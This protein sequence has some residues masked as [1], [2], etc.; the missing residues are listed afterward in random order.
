MS[1]H[2]TRLLLCAGV[3]LGLILVSA[4]GMAWF[5]LRIEGLKVAGMSVDGARVD[6]RSISMCENGGACVLLPFSKIDGL[7][8][9]MST[10]TFWSS[11]VLAII[12]AVQ[13]GSRILRGV[14]GEGI[15][16][17]GYIA[18]AL[19]FLAAAMAG[20]MFAPET[21]AIGELGVHVSRSWTPV[22][23]LAGV[24]IALY[25][26]R[27]A[28]AEELAP[29]EPAIPVATVRVAASPAPPPAEP[30][31]KRAP[32]SI[33]FGVEVVANQALQGKLRYV[34][35]IVDVSRAGIDARR[36]DGVAKLVLWTDVVGVIARRLPP[37]APYD[38][39][40]FVD[41]VSSAGST[42]RIVAWTRWNG[43]LLADEGEDRAR[44]IVQLVASR[45]PQ[46]RLDPA[47]R[48]F[49]DGHGHAAQ[50]PDLATLGVHDEQLA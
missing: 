13:A 40:T 12:V 35:A 8:P 11:L 3:A 34:A 26:L 47:T 16:R 27:L 20:F 29:R 19:C 37:E 14:A 28:V 45:C 38:S 9:T 44:A 17:I 1:K 23:M 25:T 49:V 32:S 36:E 41:V 30:P 24:V 50:L 10:V 46:A 2:Q 42:L 22:M 4:L 7:Y 5:T 15:T 43:E 21:H 48:T 33:P 31:R 18:G 39:E 6:L